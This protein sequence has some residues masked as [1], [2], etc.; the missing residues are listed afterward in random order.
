M[1]SL[2]AIFFLLPFAFLMPT[3]SL[4]VE[5]EAQIPGPALYV[6]P[7]L[8]VREISVAVT[9][10]AVTSSFIVANDSPLTLHKQFCFS[11]PPQWWFSPF[12]RDDAGF[13][14]LALSVNGKPTALQKV[15][16][17]WFD[18][19]DIT[20][21]LAKAK[22]PAYFGSAKSY[23]DIHAGKIGLDL[24]HP[25]FKK[26]YIL[27][28]DFENGKTIWCP[29]WKVHQWFAFS[30]VFPAHGTANISW[31]YA[32]RVGY[33]YS[34][35]HDHRFS[36]LVWDPREIE[37]ILP[38]KDG[39]RYYLVVWLT[40]RLDS[41][42]SPEPTKRV[43]LSVDWSNAAT[44]YYVSVMAGDKRAFGKD[45]VSLEVGNTPLSG[46][47]TFCMVRRLQEPPRGDNALH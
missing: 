13:D 27:P 9:R 5:A 41:I 3:P 4:A 2:L 29:Q 38:K 21:E 20:P 19:R 11:A 12:F 7:E 35:L 44:E 8:S 31:S 37:T 1:R 36:E 42:P 16:S 24:E 15:Y 28:S 26:G 14:D 32:P 22:L 45:A 47:A 6:A 17:A 46:E 43:S 40:V 39:D 30:H 23:S 10:K 33:Y 25:L 18:G 34:S